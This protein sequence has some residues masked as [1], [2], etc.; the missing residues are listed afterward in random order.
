MD[1]RYS[2]VLSH[3][4]I[5]KGSLAKCEI[6]KKKYSYKSIFTNFKKHLNNRHLTT[7]DPKNNNPIS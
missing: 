3:Y 5:V 4:T 2:R 1:N 7:C 6:C